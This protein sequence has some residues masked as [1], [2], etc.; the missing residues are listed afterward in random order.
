M[1]HN[2][3]SN[4]LNELTASVISDNAKLCVEY[5]LETVELPSMNQELIISS[6]LAS[7]SMATRLSTEIILAVLNQIH[8]LDLDNLQYIDEKPDLK[9][10]IGNLDK[11]F[12]SKDKG[13]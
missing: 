10:I 12:K 8:V 7:V 4:Y 9:V 6:Y 11:N 2:E 13:S 5:L 1:T 3:L